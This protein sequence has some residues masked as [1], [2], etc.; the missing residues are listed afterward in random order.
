MWAELAL[1]NLLRKHAVERIDVLHVDVEGYDWMVLR[2]FD[3]ARYRP[4]V[5][6]IER[7]SLA[8]DD[9]AA[10]RAFMRQ[11]GLTVVDFYDELVGVRTILPGT[12]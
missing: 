3:L 4:T 6:R 12:G 11:A 10:A 5:V 1:P 2:Q 7:T 9:V 8:P